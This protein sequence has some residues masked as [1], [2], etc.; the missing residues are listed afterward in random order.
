[1]VWNACGLLG[2]RKCKLDFIKSFVDKNKLNFIIITESHL[3]SDIND[4]EVTRNLNGF[5]LLRSDRNTEY[6][7]DSAKSKGGSAILYP[8]EVC[9]TKVQCFS[10]GMNENLNVEFKEL[11]LAIKKISVTVFFV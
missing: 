11:N 7:T 6:D 8:S 9:P 3:R 4:N 1:M 2:K 10:N 5:S